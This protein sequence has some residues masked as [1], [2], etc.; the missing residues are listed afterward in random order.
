MMYELS[1]DVAAYFQ[2]KTILVTGA[3]GFIGRHLVR[4]LHALGAHVVALDRSSGELLPGVRWVIADVLDL[5][6]E[7][8]EGISLDI[9]VH[10]AA[11]LGV[12]Y[13]FQNPFQT[14][15][16]NVVGTA[17][18]LKLVRALGAKV[19]CVMSSSMVCGE[20][21]V[22]PITEDSNLNTLTIYGWSKVCAE[23]LLEAHVQA[24]DLCGVIDRKSVV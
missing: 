5:T 23:Q 6:P 17:R 1:S 10:L 2:G 13:T 14:L 20:P 3:A 21:D 7:Y 16:V 22:N 24:E 4:H 19:V 12:N 8:F 11:I 15:R 18:F 9:A